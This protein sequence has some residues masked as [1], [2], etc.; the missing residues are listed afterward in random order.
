MALVHAWCAKSSIQ[1]WD[2]CISDVR[3]ISASARFFSTEYVLGKMTQ[4]HAL[5]RRGG[6]GNPLSIAVFSGATPYKIVKAP[7]SAR[8]RQTFTT[9]NLVTVTRRRVHP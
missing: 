5:G 3:C 8:K 6:H 1:T 4:I 2:S 7:F 9:K